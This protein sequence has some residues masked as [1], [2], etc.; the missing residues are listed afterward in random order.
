MKVK[1][2]GGKAQ[3]KDVGSVIGEC[4]SE[5]GLAEGLNEHKICAAWDE[6]SGAGRY[7]LNRSFRDGTLYVR[8]SS[9][10]VRS[11][12]FSRLETVRK[13]INAAVTVDPLFTCTSAETEPVKKVVLQ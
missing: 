2:Y 8:L 9:S 12:L 7:T 6:V 13:G 10:M 4:L 1:E 5:L 3:A 11:R